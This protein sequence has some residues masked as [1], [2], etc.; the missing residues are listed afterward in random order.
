MKTI[1][2][3]LFVFI[4]LLG[5]AQECPNVTKKT[6]PYT[7]KSHYSS[8]SKEIQIWKEIKDEDTLY[9]LFV[10]SACTVNSVGQKGVWLILT[11]GA[12][13]EFPDARLDVQ[14]SSPTMYPNST[15]YCRAVIRLTNADVESLACHAIAKAR[16]HTNEAYIPKALPEKI[17]LS[18]KCLYGL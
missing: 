9:F 13:M 16:V 6:D 8:P 4:A 17:R 3:A 2:T 18:I 10:L 5:N 11:N 7:L 1:T 14:V 15:Y 12:R